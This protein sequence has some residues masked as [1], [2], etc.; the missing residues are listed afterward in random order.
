MKSTKLSIS[1]LILIVT[2]LTFAFW[3]LS[4]TDT[5]TFIQN[6]TDQHKHDQKKDD[7]HKKNEL[8]ENPEHH[9]DDYD[10]EVDDGHD[11][12][13]EQIEGNEH[14]EHGDEE[15]IELTEEA[16]EMAGISIST[17]IKGRLGNS[18]N[19]PGEIT[20]NE[21]Q[22]V[23]ISPRFE[24][25]AREAR[26][27]VGDYANGGDILAVIE[28]NESMSAYNI[29]SPISGWIIMRHISK[30][31]FVSAENSI[32]VIVDLSTVWVNLAVYPRDAD[33]V[34]PDMKVSIESISSNIHAEGTIEYI[35]PIVDVN[36]R[37]I[38]ARVVLPNPNNKWRPG[39][40]VHAVVTTDYGQPGLLIEKDAVQILD[41][42]NVVFVAEG[43]GHF[44]ITRI[45][46]GEYDS[47]YIKVLSGLEQGA[48]YVA[49]GAFELKAKLVTSSLGGHAGHG[50]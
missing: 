28:S 9:D 14:D 15:V 46:T 19:L 48:Q 18:L 3:S 43:P 34:K 42:E 31:E 1:R 23:H 7:D 10:D 6:Q 47:K 49:N 26:F 13:A 44:V 36:T 29:K 20:F 11:H 12:A 37:S 45:E 25:I 32:Y 38:T 8:R 16:I 22:V 41:N 5:T 24:G 35:T 2:A 39:T 40:F 50:H 27:S 30:G 17:V 4:L 33:R 21:D